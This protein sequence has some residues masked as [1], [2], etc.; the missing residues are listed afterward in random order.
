MTQN[1]PLSKTTVVLH[2]LVAL[3]FIVMLCVGFYMVDLPR[4]PDKGEIYGIHKSVG[5][6][7]LLLVV[8]RIAWRIKEG[9]LPPVSPILTWQDKAAKGLQHFFYLATLCMPI[10][11]IM[12]SVGGGRG[13]KVFGVSVISSGE[14]IN[15]LG[16]L[17]SDIHFYC[18]W[19]L[20]VGI[21]LHI[22]A[23]LKHHF[24]DKDIRLVR[25]LGRK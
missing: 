21:S 7:V 10:S 4:G 20:V 3:C 17:G 25:I 9:K 14:K 23:A 16:S 19:A 1:S 15:W 18:A 5:A 11:G 12:M 13:L 2:W 8:G 6:I 24:L 22:L